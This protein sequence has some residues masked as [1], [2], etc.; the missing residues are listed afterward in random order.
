MDWDAELTASSSLQRRRE[1]RL[2]VPGNALEASTQPFGR[3]AD[4]KLKCWHMLLQLTTCAEPSGI[5]QPKAA[6]G[7]T[8]VD[9]EHFSV[10]TPHPLPRRL[11]K[12]PPIH[13]EYRP[14]NHHRLKAFEPGGTGPGAI[15]LRTDLGL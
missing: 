2:G 12:P 13:T 3:R 6:T 5:L 9:Y 10:R 7:I 14:V 11:D 15:S 4:G 8:I 1:L